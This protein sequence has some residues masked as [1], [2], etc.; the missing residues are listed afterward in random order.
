MAEATGKKTVNAN[1]KMFRV[2]ADMT[3]LGSAATP[4]IKMMRAW[5]QWRMT[6]GAKMIRKGAIKKK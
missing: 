6:D 2:P 5:H 4:L 3:A 1:P